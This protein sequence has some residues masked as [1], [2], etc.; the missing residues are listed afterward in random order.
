M[1]LSEEEETAA[2]AIRNPL[3]P[4][5]APNLETMRPVTEVSLDAFLITRMPI[6]TEVFGR[7]TDEAPGGYQFRDGPVNVTFDTAARFANSLG[8]TLPSEAQREYACR[9]G[10]NTL[11]VWGNGLPEEAVLEQWLG[12]EFAD[13]YE[14]V[15]QANDFGLSALFAAEWCRDEYR[16]GHD[17]SL[18]VSTGEH[19]VKG[20]GAN[21]WPWQDEEWIWCISAIRM[22]ESG[23]IMN[24][25]DIVLDARAAFRLVRELSCS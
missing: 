3:P 18:P 24:I 16:P 10:T 20:G 11:F 2:R 4:I 13:G 22:A 14:R 21:W 15:L 12:S 19:V 6:T 9:G 7:L 23:L 1:G 17:T 8:F 25:R 5:L